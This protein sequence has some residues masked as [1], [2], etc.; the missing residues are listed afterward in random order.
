MSIDTNSIQ[1]YVEMPLELQF[2][3]IRILIYGYWIDMPGRCV[4]FGK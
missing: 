3:T 4:I 1:I 2:L